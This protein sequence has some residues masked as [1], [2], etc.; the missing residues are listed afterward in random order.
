MAGTKGEFRPVN[1]VEGGMSMHA[2]CR[3]FRHGGLHS[4][5]LLILIDTVFSNLQIH[6]ATSCVFLEGLG[7]LSSYISVCLHSCSVIREFKAFCNFMLESSSE[8][9]G[10]HRVFTQTLIK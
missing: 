7:N 4:G 6:T 5:M 9:L 10:E 1:D 2:L 3:H 8:L